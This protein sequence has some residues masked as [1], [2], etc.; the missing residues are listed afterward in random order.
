MLPL[1]SGPSGLSELISFVFVCLSPLSQDGPDLQGVPGGEEPH[2]AALVH[3][4][5]LPDQTGPE[6]PQVPPAAEG[7]GVA[8][9]RPEPRTQ[10]PHRYLEG[11]HGGRLTAR[12]GFIESH[13]VDSETVETAPPVVELGIAVAVSD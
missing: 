2:Q 7:A 5:V 13:H 3:V 10:P 4:G 11:G 1:S 8:D 9:G 6:G 12:L